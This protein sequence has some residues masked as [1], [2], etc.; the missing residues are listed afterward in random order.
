MFEV[1]RIVVND[2]GMVGFDFVGVSVV[3]VVVVVML[4]VMVCDVVIG[5]LFWDEIVVVIW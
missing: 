4:I 3:V 1:S 2:S 5:L